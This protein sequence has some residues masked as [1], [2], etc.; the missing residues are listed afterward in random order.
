M[1]LWRNVRSV[2]RTLP[3][4]FLVLMLK[5]P[6]GPITARPSRVQYWATVRGVEQ[7]AKGSGMNNVDTMQ[8]VID[9]AKRLVSNVGPDQ[10]SNKT[11]CTEWTVRDLINHITGGATMVGMSI[12]QGSVP[13]DVVGKT[14]TNADCLGDDCKGA[15]SAAADEFSRIMRE[16]GVLEKTV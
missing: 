11:T 2:T 5:T 8:Q 15:F 6:A 9:E 7:S 3:A 1:S 4:R 13:D 12:E 10:L 14:M 16:P